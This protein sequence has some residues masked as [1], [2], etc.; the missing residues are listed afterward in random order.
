MKKI[1]SVVFVLLCSSHFQLISQELPHRAYLIKNNI[2]HYIVDQENSIP[3]SLNNN[4]IFLNFKKGA[5]LKNSKEEYISTNANFIEVEISRSNIGRAVLDAEIYNPKDSTIYRPKIKKE[6]KIIV[7]PKRKN[8]P[9]K[10]KFFNS[11]NFEKEEPHTLHINYDK[12]GIDTLKIVFKSS[13]ED[14]FIIKKLKVIPLNSKGSTHYENEEKK[15]KRFTDLSGDNVSLGELQK[16][17]SKLLDKMYYLHQS[18][19]FLVL[20][21]E[22]I[23]LENI[24]KSSLNPFYNLNFV[25]FYNRN[26]QKVEKKVK[27]SKIKYLGESKSFLKEGKISNLKELFDNEKFLDIIDIVDK[28]FK[29]SVTINNESILKIGSEYY[30][31][32]LKGETKIGIRKIYDVSQKKQIETILKNNQ[33]YRDYL[34]KILSYNIRDN[35]V[36]EEVSIKLVQLKELRENLRNLI[37]SIIKNYV[38]NNKNKNNYFNPINPLNPILF[39]S[40]KSDFENSYNFSQSNLLNLRKDYEINYLMFKS[41]ENEISKIKDITK[42]YYTQLYNDYPNLRK[43]GFSSIKIIFNAMLL[44]DWKTKQN[45]IIKEFKKNQGLCMKLS[46]V[47]NS[48]VT[49]NCSL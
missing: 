39:G 19:A 41:L 28:V 18:V 20:S 46:K 5:F 3:F 14:R 40:V 38:P 17:Y 10:D 37:W 44:E 12:D 26:L 7:V 24:R 8:N 48:D 34:Q 1:A 25:K 23:T 6:G 43:N 47:T 33:A 21:N 13:G 49:K 32:D 2:S 11:I 16:A 30:E 42:E 27:S 29:E 9:F 35:K 31:Q 36:N 15:I 22:V 4:N 45:N